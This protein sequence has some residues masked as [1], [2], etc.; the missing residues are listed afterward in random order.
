MS[1]PDVQ[2]QSVLIGSGRGGDARRSLSW[3][4]VVWVAWRQDRAKLIVLL[5]AFAAIA[6]FLVVT[7]L[8]MRSTWSRLG[9][10]DCPPQAI[11]SHAAENTCI[12]KLQVFLNQPPASLVGYVTWG[13]H[14]VPL[15]IGMFVGA[16]A[17]AREFETGT[18]RFAWTQS[19]GRSRWLVGKFTFLGASCFIGALL[20]GSLFSWWYSLF[21]FVASTGDRWSAQAFGLHGPSYAGWTLFCLAVGV[22]VGILTRRTVAAMA[23]TGAVS[24]VSALLASWLLRPVLLQIAPVVAQRPYKSWA[25]G[26]LSVG[27]AWLADPTGYRLTQ[28][29]IEGVL[30]QADAVP[31]EQFDQ[32][33]SNAGYTSWASYQPADRFWIF[34]TIEC[35]GLIILGL[36][37]L[38]ATVQW[39][40]RRIA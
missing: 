4:S 38:A 14:S 20:I 15:L 6:S 37:L 26:D 33:L 27:E 5:V 11:A 12:E 9:L 16:P 40:Q 30:R 2:H 8:Q 3:R 22:F 21:D 28:P 1:R 39:S 24:A 17:I 36:L 25:V 32:W 19:I 13:L 31:R 34:Q 29:E 10:G 23:I 35:L 18:F 7:G